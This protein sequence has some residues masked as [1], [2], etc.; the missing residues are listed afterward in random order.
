MQG[1]CETPAAPSRSGT[2]PSSL[3]STPSWAGCAP[4]CCGKQAAAE[5]APG[6]AFARC[7][8]SQP[9]RTCSFQA[10]KIETTTADGVVLDPGTPSP[11]SLSPVQDDAPVFPVPSL[12]PF[13]LKDPAGRPSSPREEVSCQ[14]SFFSPNYPLEIEVGIVILPVFIPGEG[15]QTSPLLAPFGGSEKTCHH[16]KTNHVQ[17]DAHP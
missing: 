13:L 11:S 8:G 9:F 6:Q 4:G 15:R 10:V 3:C 17:Q 1:G 16:P 2:G 5:Q 12:H 14:K 7:Q